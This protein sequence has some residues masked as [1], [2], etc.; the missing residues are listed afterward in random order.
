MPPGGPYPRWERVAAPCPLALCWAACRG[1]W[2]NRRAVFL[3]KAAGVKSVGATLQSLRSHCAPPSERPSLWFSAS[4]AGSLSHAPQEGAPHCCTPGGR[5]PT[6]LALFRLR[7]G[8]NP[9]GNR[10]EHEM[11]AFSKM[12][13]GGTW[14]G[15]SGGAAT[16]C[17]HF[18]K[19]EQ[20]RP[21]G[22]LLRAR[23]PG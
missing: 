20:P 3:G 12:E 8:R 4:R 7:N 2:A 11:P 22:R 16:G 6:G 15:H 10:R 5:G 13:E 18:P 19:G 17:S 21:L 23:E 1:L 14:E 9:R